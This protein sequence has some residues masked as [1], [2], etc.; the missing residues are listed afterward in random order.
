MRVVNIIN[1]EEG[2]I[3]P[4]VIIKEEIRTRLTDNWHWPNPRDW[5]DIKQ[6]KARQEDS[7][8]KRKI[9]LIQAGNRN[10][11]VFQSENKLYSLLYTLKLLLGLFQQYVFYFSIMCLKV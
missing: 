4:K 11:C 8:E 3:Q 6:N 7:E 10:V 2:R 1:S 9:T 5:P